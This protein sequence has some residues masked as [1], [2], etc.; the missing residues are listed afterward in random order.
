MT[1]EAPS[2][3][4]DRLVKRFND[5]TAVDDVSFSVDHGEIFGFLGPKGAGKSTSIRMLCALLRPSSGAASVAG[6]DVQRYA[7][8]VRGSIGYMSQKLSL[9]SDL[10]VVENLRFFGGVYGARGLR[11]RDRVDFAIEMAGLAERAEALVSTLSG[12]WKQR[13]ALGCAILHEPPVIFLDEPRSGVDPISRRRFWDLIYSLSAGGVTVLVST[14][15]MDDAGYCNRVALIDRGRLVALGSPGQLK[16]S[17]IPGEIVLI[18]SNDG[19][20][21]FQFCRACPARVTSRRL[22][23]RSTWWSTM[24]PSIFLVSKIAFRHEDWL[25]LESSTS[26]QHWKMSLSE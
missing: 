23:P 22:D 25:Y 15:Y 9:Y 20:H 5:F 6:F 19:A 12:G 4:V 17:S 18:E 3:I 16:H 21:Y 10:S 8:R 24:P 2:I 14:H 1:H 26:H 7:E 13:L 11:L